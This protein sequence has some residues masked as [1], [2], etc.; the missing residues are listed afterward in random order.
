M[1]LY[2]ELKVSKTYEG[3]YGIKLDASHCIQTALSLQ[4]PK[5]GFMRLDCYDWVDPTRSQTS[6]DMTLFETKIKKGLLLMQ[7]NDLNHT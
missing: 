1:G 6:V 5:T 2:K 4:N 7:G 3:K